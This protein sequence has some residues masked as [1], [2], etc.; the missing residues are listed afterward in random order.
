MRRASLVLLLVAACGGP[1]IPQ[2]NGYKSDKVKPWKKAKTLKF[3][4][5]M[6]AKSEGDLNYAAMRRAAWFN[7][8]TPSH[9][10]LDLRVEITPPGD[11][12]NENFD[13][14]FEVLDP[15][16]R[17]IS[18]SDLEE[19]EGQGEL[20]K[21]KTLVDLAPGKYLVHLY[22]QGR[23]DSADYV[24][25]AT[26]KPTTASD[27]KTD[28]PSQV[29]FLPP[30]A[31]VPLN[32]DTPKSYHPP[33]VTT[34]VHTKFKPKDKPKDPTPPPVSTAMTARIIGLQVVGGGIQI[35]VGRGTANGA[36]V[37]MKGSIVGISGA[38][39]ALTACSE[40]TCT[41]TVSKVTP[42]QVKGGAS[43]TLTP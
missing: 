37:G 24:L 27:A 38:N 29:A 9:G 43:V 39:F 26:F 18:R 21:V 13:L 16:N 2:H 42:D 35:T 31:M 32:D 40:R 20:N 22:L 23:M 17:S 41:A 1:Q 25:H 14:G 30:L 6:E 12:V 5:K 34:V 33:A 19:G 28:F 11:G 36:S 10:Q 7:V 8:E 3:N 15:A 4:D